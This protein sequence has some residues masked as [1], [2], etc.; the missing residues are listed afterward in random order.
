MNKFLLIIIIA[1]VSF[2]SFYFLTGKFMK[3][4]PTDQ[5]KLPPAASNT[6]TD[7]ANDSD[8]ID[9]TKFTT[10]IDNKYFSLPVGR[11]LTYEGKTED[12]LEKIEITINGETKKVMGVETLIYRDK[13]WLD[14]ELVEDTKDYLAQDNEG[15]VWYF[16]EDVDNY[17][18]GKLKDHSGS[19]LAGV[20][21]AQPGIWMKA[22]HTVG[23]SYRQEYYKNEAED[24][25]D[26]V[27]INE[28]ITTKLGT[29]KNCVKMYNWTPLDPDSKENKVYCP[30]V[31]A[32]VL[33]TDLVS[34]ESAELVKVE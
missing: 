8:N 13:V 9:P 30:E 4:K 28:T 14:N 12:G 10:K 18:D 27:S 7:E 19:W 29:Y 20:D 34:N 5:A 16:G 33:E 3:P 25:Q 21:G 2:A 1:L 31:N 24:M 15:N 6:V 17:E 11:K 26:V 23:D 32:M 22:K